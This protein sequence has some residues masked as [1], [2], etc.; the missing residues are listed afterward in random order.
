M[1]TTT[2]HE[3]WIFTFS[4]KSS[5]LKLTIHMNLQMF[6]YWYLNDI[7]WWSFTWIHSLVKFSRNWYQKCGGCFMYYGFLLFMVSWYLYLIYVME[8]SCQRSDL[9]CEAHEL[10]KLICYEIASKLHQFAHNH[11]TNPSI[12]FLFTG[13]CF[14]ATSY[15]VC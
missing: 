9:M 5:L 14:S 3:D 7:V 15:W 10:T 6:L 13:C 12:S 2:E 11:I 1:R 8:N 4:K